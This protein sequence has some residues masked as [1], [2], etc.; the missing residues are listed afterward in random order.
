MSWTYVAS[1]LKGKAIVGT[2]YQQE[3][4]KTNQK[5]FRVEKLYLKWRDH[6]SFLTVRFIKK[7]W[8]KRR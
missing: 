2:F 3:F 4:Q 6:D 8:Y 1:D 5:Q 7:T